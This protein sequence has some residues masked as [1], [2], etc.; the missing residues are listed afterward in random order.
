MVQS[1]KCFQQLLASA[2]AEPN[3]IKMVIVTSFLLSE[4]VTFC[5]SFNFDIDP[6]EIRV[7]S[8][9]VSKNDNLECKTE[10]LIKRVL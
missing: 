1:F 4:S 10:M 5:E 8:W 2:S 9:V 3:I 6:R 7:I